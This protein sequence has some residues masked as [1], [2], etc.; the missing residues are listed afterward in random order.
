MTA[1]NREPAPVSGLVQGMLSPLLGSTSDTPGHS[2]GAW[3][4]LAAARRELSTRTAM[5]TTA[6]VATGQ[7]VTPTANATLASRISDL[8][9]AALRRLRS[10]FFNSSPTATPVQT[11]QSDSG[12]V[13][14][15]LGAKDPDGDP[16]TYSVTKAPAHGGV[17]INADGTFTYAPDL[18]AAH[19][20]VTDSF[21]ATITESNS[22]THTHGLSGFLAR[23]RGALN[24]ATP[25]LND[26]HSIQAV[27]PVT[28]TPVNH[29][30][31]TV[32]LTVGTPDP[33]TG[34]VT[35]TVVFTDSDGDPLGYTVAAR[36][37][38]GSV[39]VGADGNFV[40]T[41]TAEARH[42]AAKVGADTSASTDSFTV[43]A[44]DGYGGTAALRVSLPVGPQNQA[45]IVGS[46]SVGSPDAATGVVTGNMNFNDP[47]NDLLTYTVAVDPTLATASVGADG[48]FT[49]TPTPEA[50]HAASAADADAQA[51]FTVTADDGH[52]GTANSSVQVSIT[53]MNAAPTI[54]VTDVS[55]PAQDGAV[56]ITYTVSDPDNT[57]LDNPT[58]TLV[59]H[60]AGTTNTKFLS[61][62]GDGTLTYS[63][64]DMA[65]LNAGGVGGITTDVITLT[66]TDGHGA[67]ATTTATV[68][69]APPSGI[70]TP[71]VEI[72]ATDPETGI[73]TGTI[74]PQTPTPLTYAIGR[75]P[76][77]GS[78]EVDANTGNWTFTPN[79]LGLIFTWAGNTTPTTS[80]SVTASDGTQSTPVTVTVPLSVSEDALI[81][82]LKRSGDV[83]PGED[84]APTIAVGHNGELII[85]N[86]TTGEPT[87]ISPKSTGLQTYNASSW[88]HG[89]SIAGAAIAV[90]KDG[91]IYVA[92]GGYFDTN[93]ATYDP[94][95]GFI[96][97]IAGF[98]NFLGGVKDLAVDADGRVYALLSAPRSQTNLYAYDPRT[99]ITTTLLSNSQISQILVGNDNKL[100]VAA[101][102]YVVYSDDGLQSNTLP[103]RLV[104]ID[105]ADD[106]S[107]RSVQ[108]SPDTPGT[109]GYAMRIAE[110][111]NGAI[112]A[113]NIGTD[114]ENVTAPKIAVVGPGETSALTHDLDLPA[115]DVTIGTN[116]KI[117][118]ANGGEPSI[119]VL[120]GD[121]SVDAVLPT[122]LYP[123]SLATGSDGKI[124]AS[125]IANAVV[126]TTTLMV[127]DPS[128][129]YSLSV[130]NVGGA[131]N[132]PGS[133][134]DIASGA[135]GTYA[136]GVSYM[137]GASGGTYAVNRVAT[138]GEDAISATDAPKS[139]TGLWKVVREQATGNDVT[140]GV[141]M[142]TVHGL[143]DNYRL[144]VYLGGTTGD[145]FTGDQAIAENLPTA[146]GVLKKDQIIA[147]KSAL[148]SCSQACPINEIMLVGFS[149][150]GMDAQNL[151]APD[152]L[153]N[154]PLLI[155]PALRDTILALPSL[156]ST[157]I[158]FGSPIIALPSPDDAVLHVQELLDPVPKTVLLLPNKLYSPDFKTV[159]SAA[160]FPL[161][162]AYDGLSGNV[163][164]NE[165]N[166]LLKLLGPHTLE[167][168]YT[169]LSNA[170]AYHT[171]GQHTSVKEA[172]LRF[173]G[174]LVNPALINP[175]PEF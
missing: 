64:T 5:F 172:I 118:L 113:V 126:S 144:I 55:D 79:L 69:I 170:F 27:V 92:S 44:A 151:A 162:T 87:V 107:V 150:G 104:I 21:T 68:Q 71:K 74:T 146:Q 108:L 7:L 46:P 114:T 98:S 105:P 89:E 132:Q 128:N 41:P 20:G 102:G 159:A 3:L 28:V 77:Y 86:N 163:S 140:D 168:T 22:A 135:S 31:I 153:V 76:L 133:V 115:F 166:P 161:G 42:N 33:V 45:P 85:V 149:Q 142:Q 109:R 171:A 122:G 157:V 17:V 148:D 110:G 123:I 23:L 103:K 11:S 80:F 158:T 18:A 160:R 88:I 90:G 83:V 143:D 152:L 50:R 174:T 94:G 60:P 14:G 6:T 121:C 29:A 66:V 116:G 130:V 129:N 167:D 51:S 137:P 34:D 47:E 61:L 124:L 63:P 99:G 78:A 12:I 2:P 53:P 111:P 91:S 32:S 131:P 127:I 84:P 37:A 155:D 173:Q 8:F 52:G 54:T 100:Y 101:D 73:S 82:L 145:L 154:A 120:N 65:R 139:L 70:P 96:S 119:T 97:H 93:V 165:S 43:S 57:N 147:I 26:G 39:R 25:G 15:T 156:V 13:T 72:T 141:I 95:G 36:P 67:S 30:P 125:T 136:L 59:V 134:V 24:P 1:P 38:R 35:G 75:P 56:T 164:N 58:D 9:T 48:T 62:N 10:S 175:L 16:L 106:Y 169:K 117:Y 19:E 112:Y 49:F 81:S 138:N 4:M 40:Y